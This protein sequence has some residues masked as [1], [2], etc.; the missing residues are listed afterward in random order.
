MESIVPVWSDVARPPK[1]DG[2]PCPEHVRAHFVL[3][4]P[5]D[6]F[7][8]FFDPEGYFRCSVID[9]GEF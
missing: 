7:L 8:H 6:F 9:L 4:L 1:R 2:W 3:V 5:Y